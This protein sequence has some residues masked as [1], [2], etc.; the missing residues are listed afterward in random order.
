MASEKGY[1]DIISYLIEHNADINADINAKDKDEKTAL[2]YSSREEIKNYLK[3]NG[4]RD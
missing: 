2:Q 4:A 3:Q 1:L